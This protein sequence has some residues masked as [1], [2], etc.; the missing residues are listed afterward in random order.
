MAQYIMEKLAIGMLSE[1]ERLFPR[2]VDGQTIDSSR[3]AELI[4]QRTS[5]TR[6]DAMGLL[7]EL[8]AIV[9]EQIADGNSVKINGLGTLRPV[10]GLVDKDKRGEWTDSAN[11]TTTSRNVRLKTIAFRPDSQLFGRA[12]HGMNLERKSNSLGRKRPSTT[13]EERAAMAR[14]YIA[15]HGFMRVADYVAL[16]GLARSTASAELRQLA[17]DPANGISTNGTGSNKVYVSI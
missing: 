12:S 6:G 15:E 1:G 9:E 4:E 13:I 5:F 3:I 17:A 16:T 11:R 2:L 14:Q 10:L 8:A 7:T